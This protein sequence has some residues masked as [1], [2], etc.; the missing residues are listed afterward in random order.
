MKT[1]AAIVFALW[2]GGL[3]QAEPNGV[4]KDFKTK[5]ELKAWATDP[6]F[7]ATLLEF[8][9]RSREYIAVSLKRTSGAPSSEV[10]L[11]VFR[12]GHWSA[13]L[14]LGDPE[15]DAEVTV[16]KGRFQV[17]KLYYSVKSKKPGYS[18]RPYVELELDALE[19]EP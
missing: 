17:W 11:F 12:Y 5:K 6:F 18:K 16:S 1:L 13:I 10:F 14:H 19:F 4:I 9:H 15:F 8:K 3:L 2:F 7:G